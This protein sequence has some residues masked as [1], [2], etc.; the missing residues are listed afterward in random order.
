MSDRRSR[1]SPNQMNQQVKRGQ[2]PSS[3]KRVDKGVPERYDRDDHIHFQSGEALCTQMENG[4][5]AKKN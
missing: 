1:A 3:I 5:M 4:N 2:S